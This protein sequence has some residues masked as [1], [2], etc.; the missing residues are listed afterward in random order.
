MFE[1]VGSP[2]DHVQKTLKDYLKE[3]KK[4]PHILMISEEHAEPRQK[5]KLWSTFCEAEMLILGLEKL[6]WLCINYTPASIEVLQP[7]TLTYR[8][9]DITSWSN[10]LLSKLHE[11]GII[12]KSLNQKN[13]VLEHNLST[14]VRNCI[15]AILESEQSVGDLCKA[16][17]I[18]KE[19]AQQFLNALEH[20]GRIK[21]K[22]LKYVRR[23]GNAKER[24]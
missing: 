23:M 11:I 18:P 20:E 3:I 14:I 5:D 10:D 6:S 16:I 24:G 13:K 8:D 7:S 2:K 19:N 22:G 9:K 1:V 4:D 15:L 17:G 21:K 12:T